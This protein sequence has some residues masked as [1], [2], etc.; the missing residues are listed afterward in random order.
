MYALLQAQKSIG[1]KQNVNALYIHEDTYLC[2]IS[3][4]DLRE[5][6]REVEAGWEFVR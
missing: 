1:L 4:L 5:L 2:Q 6:K 3:P